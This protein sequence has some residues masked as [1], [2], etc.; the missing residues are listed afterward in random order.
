ML[1]KSLLVLFVLS[2]VGL[3]WVLPRGNS[4][5]PKASEFLST[6]IDLGV[7]VSD[8]EKSVKF[9]TEAIGFK[10]VKGF[11][12][13]A[14]FAKDTGLTSS[15]GFKVRVLVLGE[16]DAATKLKLIEMADEKPKKNDN[17]VVHSEL[18][19]RYITLVTADTTAALARLTKAGVKPVAKSPVGLP[20]GFPEGWFLTIVKD[21]DGN[22]VEL[23]GPK[24]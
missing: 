13:P 5:D 14:E 2:L 17:A 21:P 1:R 20:K 9:Y 22:M 10:E 7:L 16:G 12:I 6:T 3:G 15:K 23:V 4:A 11:E 8:I 18:G 24:K 19:Y